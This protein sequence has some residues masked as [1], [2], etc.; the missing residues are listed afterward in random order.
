[1]YN[2]LIDYIEKHH[3][4]YQYQFGFRKKSFYIYGIINFTRKKP[5]MHWI[6]QNLQ[7]AYL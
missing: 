5:L 6:I 2:I 3:L 7:F 4:L 1:M